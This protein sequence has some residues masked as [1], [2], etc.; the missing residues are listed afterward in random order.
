METSFNLLIIIPTYNEVQN[1]KPLLEKIKK[2][3]KKFHLLFVDDNS[4]DGTRQAIMQYKK[5]LSLSIIHRKKKMGLASAYIEGLQQGLKKNYQYFLQMDADMSHN[6]KYI[7]AMLEKIQNFD[8]VIGSRYVVGGGVSGW[9]WN[10]KIISYGG[11]LYARIILKSKIK[12]LTGGF[13]M[14]RKKTLEKIDLNSIFSKGYVFQIE[15]KTKALAQNM[16][17]YE[18]PIIFT[19]RITGKSKIDKQIIFEAF[20]NVYKLPKQ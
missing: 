12:D 1:I 7:P 20:K 4:S 5:D 15:M 3:Q 11:N 6:P 8:F 14:W 2:I 9:S 19:D 10:R 17:Y 18:L 16:C 13:N